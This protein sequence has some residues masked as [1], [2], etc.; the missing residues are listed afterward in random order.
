MR[1]GEEKD[2]P[3]VAPSPDP[4]PR[5]KGVE[6]DRPCVAPPP[7]PS[8]DTDYSEL[9]E[10]A[11]WWVFNNAKPRL[12]SPSSKENKEAGLHLDFRLLVLSDVKE[13]GQRSTLL[14][15]GSQANRAAVLD[16]R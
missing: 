13:Y 8:V 14:L 1:R 9:S 7:L 10:W 3:C 4:L 16:R 12:G 11:G 6:K 2:R 15:L 5:R